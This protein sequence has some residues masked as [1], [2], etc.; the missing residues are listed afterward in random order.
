MRI[1]LDFPHGG[2]PYV[3]RD[4]VKVIRVMDYDGVSLA[5]KELQEWTHRGY[6][7]AGFVSYEA[8]YALVEPQK[9]ASDFISHAPR[10]TFPLLGFG[11]FNAPA[12]MWD[13][14]LA[15]SYRI[16]GWVLDPPMTRKDYDQKI[17]DIRQLIRQGLSY[18]INFT[19]RLSSSFEGDPWLFYMHLR[20]TQKASYTAYVKWDDYAILS[21][22]PEL[23]FAQN[24]QS[25]LTRPMKGTAGRGRFYTEDMRYRE[26]LEKSEK[27]RAENI[28]IADLFRNDLA[29][30]DPRGIVEVCSLCRAEAYPTL[31][32]LTSE[33]RSKTMRTVPWS[34]V[35]QKLYPSG[36]ITGAPK[37]S[38]MKIIQELESSP[39]EIY[40]GTIGYAAPYG[41]AEF[42]VAIRTVW[43][44]QGRHQARFGT[45]GGI[46]WDSQPGEEYEEILTKSRFLT[47]RQSNWSLLETMKLESGRIWLK[48][49][50]LS[51]ILEAA[52]YYRIPLSLGILQEY[53][54]Q[55]EEQYSKGLWRVRITVNESGQI[56][57]ETLSWN[58]LSPGVH[59]VSWANEP[60]SSTDPL[61]FHKTTNR[62]FFNRIHTQESQSFDHLLWNEKEEVT[63]FTR[64]N[65]VILHRGELLT[66]A[67]ESGLLAGTFRAILLGHKIIRE[68]RIK[69]QTMEDCKKIWFINSLYGWVPVVLTH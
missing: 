26:E 10:P 50:H 23:F 28:M 66:P 13:V 46:T 56:E 38:S 24:G 55:I 39:R 53:L 17:A 57:S 35:L 31:W 4:P 61:F 40:C 41:Q 12:K 43:I 65:V 1:R 14:G 37:L 20:Q 21:M 63:E 64:G 22:S 69:R 15:T 47:Q 59:K 5:L 3:F 51:R 2:T 33:I 19:L 36:S 34:E 60:G 49:Y 25:V 6:W 58:S 9:Y 62:D 7:V 27:N 54:R 8:A 16:G 44:D 11:V 18:Q 42:N 52:A 45:G 29:R 48:S 67:R 68:E 32:Q 30:I